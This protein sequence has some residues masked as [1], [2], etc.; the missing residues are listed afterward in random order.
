MIST[1]RFFILIVNLSPVFS[2]TDYKA[3]AGGIKHRGRF[4]K[5]T[6]YSPS[7]KEQRCREKKELGSSRFGQCST[8][9]ARIPQVQTGMNLQ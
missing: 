2:G 7:K 8:V 5:I 4:L 1:E 3:E 6:E 9:L